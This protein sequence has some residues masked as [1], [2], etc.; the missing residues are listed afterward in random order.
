MRWLF[1][2]KSREELEQEL[3]H[4]DDIERRE[5]RGFRK[6]LGKAK[7]ENLRKRPLTKSKRTKPR[8]LKGK[9]LNSIRRKLRR[10]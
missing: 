2:L 7:R 1:F 5:A 6:L 9:R 10:R 3:R 4:R 8:I